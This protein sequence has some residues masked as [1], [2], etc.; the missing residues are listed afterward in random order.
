MV[1]LDLNYH[2]IY[3]TK[4]FALF[5][6][7]VSLINLLVCQL[8]ITNN[9]RRDVLEVFCFYLLLAGRKLRKLRK[10]VGFKYFLDLSCLSNHL[11]EVQLKYLSNLLSLFSVNPISD[12][13]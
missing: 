3:F 12:K 10:L 4:L 8:W 11:L 1:Q 9:H 2:N 7:Q 6:L 5:V 13:F